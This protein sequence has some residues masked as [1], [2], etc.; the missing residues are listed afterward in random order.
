ML[1][2]DDHPLALAGNALGFLIAPEPGAIKR[3]VDSLQSRGTHLTTGAVGTRWILQAL[4]AANRT[5]VALDLAT[6]KSAPSWYSFVALG[7]GT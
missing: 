3:L 7:P 2:Y 1:H 6:Q 4:T 5:D